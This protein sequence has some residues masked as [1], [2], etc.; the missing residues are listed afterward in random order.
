MAWGLAAALGVLS[1]AAGC[2]DAPTPAAPVGVDSGVEACEPGTQGCACLGGSGCRDD[3]LCVARRC[4]V[5]EGPE[6]TEPSARP[7]PVPR[8]PLPPIVDPPDTG[9]SVPS[10]D[11]GLDASALDGGGG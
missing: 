7:R 10:E 1:S 5:T 8:D 6:D 2:D 9:S 3:L 4:L 11:A